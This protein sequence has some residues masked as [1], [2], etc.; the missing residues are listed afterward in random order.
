MMSKTAYDQGI[1]RFGRIWNSV[2][3]LLLLAVPFAIC[4]LFDIFPPANNLLKGQIG[5]AHV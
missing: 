3:V 1:H 5:R 2:V 4:L